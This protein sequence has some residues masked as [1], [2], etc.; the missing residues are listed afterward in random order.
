MQGWKGNKNPFKNRQNL[1]LWQFA[2]L[3]APFS[4]KI[5]D[6][7]GDLKHPKKM[8]RKKRSFPPQKNTIILWLIHPKIEF[9]AQKGSLFILMAEQK[10]YKLAVLYSQMRSFLKNWDETYKNILNTPPGGFL[11][12]WYPTTMGFPTKM[13]ILGCFEG[14][15][16]WGNTHHLYRNLVHIVDPKG[17]EIFVVPIRPIGCTEPQGRVLEKDSELIFLFPRGEGVT[18][19]FPS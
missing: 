10:E 9:L 1:E 15:S 3:V 4:S 13:I 2:T 17:P 6:M 5:N 7:E 18:G 12:W 16:I 14:T 19:F 8:Y 11:K